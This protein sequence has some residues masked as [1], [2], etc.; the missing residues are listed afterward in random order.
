MAELF[1]AQGGVFSYFEFSQPRS[2]R[3]SDEAW[4]QRLAGNPPSR[5]AW[6]TSFILPGGEARSVLA[7]RMND[8]YI[9]TAE[10]GSPALNVRAEPATT[11]SVNDTLL[12]GAYI[13]IVD[14]PVMAGGNTW[15]K[16]QEEFGEAA[17][18]VAENQAWYERAYGQ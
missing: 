18:W 11:A 4:R 16:I 10:G 17:G 15:W 13:R 7:F 12:P 14:G 1:V 2:A 8:V 3:L 5:P 9:I 6:T